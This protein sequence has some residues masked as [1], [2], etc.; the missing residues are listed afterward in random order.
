MLLAFSVDSQLCLPDSVFGL[1]SFQVL[2]RLSGQV[3]LGAIYSNDQSNELASLPE[4]SGG[5]DS[6]PGDALFVVFSY[7]PPQVP[8]VTGLLYRLSA[9]PASLSAQV[10]LAMKLP[11]VQVRCNWELYS[12]VRS[13]PLLGQVQDRLQVW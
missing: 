9:P 4:Q 8:C 13:A 3:G 6:E 1:W 2:A 12:A 11:G 5:T 7:A 10:L